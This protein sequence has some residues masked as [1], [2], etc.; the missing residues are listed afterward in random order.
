MGEVAA[1]AQALTHTGSLKA[2]QFPAVFRP[3]ALWLLR[4]H[5]FCGGAHRL[6]PRSENLRYRPFTIRTIYQDSYIAIGM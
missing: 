6:C 4:S 2:I 1:F 5:R 3:R